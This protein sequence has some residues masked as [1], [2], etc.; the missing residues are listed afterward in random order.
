MYV[1]IETDGENLYT[2]GFYTPNTGVWIPESDH[3]DKDA[4]AQRV[5][6]LNGGRGAPQW[7]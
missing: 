4:A 7:R 6:Y 3:P 2:V 5:N 1:Y